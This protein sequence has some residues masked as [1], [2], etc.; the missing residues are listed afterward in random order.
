MSTIDLVQT[1]GI[2]LGL[3]LTFFQMR[4]NNKTL[5]VS[6][7]ATISERNNELTRIFF[8]NPKV[9]RNLSRV[10]K[11]PKDSFVLIPESAL[12]YQ[13]LNFLDE[14][15]YYFQKKVIDKSTW[16]AYL[17]SSK[18][19]VSPLLYVKGFWEDVRDEYSENLQNEI[20]QLFN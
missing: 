12:C 11:K 6:I 3:A 4:A 7:Y 19:L 20:D 5:R 1:L 9:L 8:D 14:L 18:R 13:L 2:V 16:K 17:A 10:Y 15:H